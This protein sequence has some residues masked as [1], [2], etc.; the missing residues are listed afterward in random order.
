MEVVA[1]VD[2]REAPVDTGLVLVMARAVL[3]EDTAAVGRGDRMQVG[4]PIGLRVLRDD[5]R[6]RPGPIH[7]DR[8]RGSVLPDR[9]RSSR[10]RLLAPAQEDVRRTSKSDDRENACDREGESGLRVRHVA[11]L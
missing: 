4:T 1:S 7:R 8:S 11:L 10:G 5:R 2:T 6:G 9:Q 3:G